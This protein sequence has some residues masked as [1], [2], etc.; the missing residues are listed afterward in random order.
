LDKRQRFSQDFKDALITKIVNRNGRTIASIC[1]EVGVSY[2][3]AHNWIKRRVNPEAVNTKKRRERSE[4]EKLQ[5][6][7]KV[8]TLTEE[9]LGLYFREIGI[10][11]HQYTNWRSLA[12]QGLSVRR[13]EAK[14]VPEDARVKE[15]E[16]DLSRMEKALAEMAAREVLKKKAD[17]TWSRYST[18]KNKH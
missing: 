6:I 2:L 17:I 13:M 16:Q 12:L 3:T 10:Y 18:E 4:E 7:C 15:L 14:K 9:Q 1:E 11:D 5:I 8:S